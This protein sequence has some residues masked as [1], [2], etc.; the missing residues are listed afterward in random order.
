MKFQFRG[1]IPSSK[2]GLNRAW[3]A[4]SYF[5]NLNIHGDSN[6]DDVR[7]MKLGL[8]HLA[9]KKEIFC[10]DA[11]TVFRFLAM[12]AS[13]E[14][15]VWTLTGTPRLLSRPHDDLIFI[16]NQSELFKNFL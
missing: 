2:S 8:L 5:S 11:G 4:K 1:E 15:G 9:Q 3:L 7:Y 12:R 10:G 14:P 13:R 6:C 16:M